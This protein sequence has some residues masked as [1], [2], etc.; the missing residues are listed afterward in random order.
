MKRVFYGLIIAGTFLIGLFLSV[1]TVNEMEYAIVT[2]FGKPVR[3]IYDAGLQFKLPGFFETVNRIDRQINVFITQPI[4]LLLGD[5][6]PIILTCYVCWRVCDPSL[7][8]QSLVL[9]ETA[10]QKLGDM[11]NSQLGSVLGDYRLSQIINT[12][13][14]EVML[15]EIESKIIGNANPNVKAKY[16]L[17]ILQLGVRRINYPSIVAKAVFDRMQSEREK[18]AKKYRAEGAEESAK[19][20]AQTEREVSEI[21]ARAYKESEQ[22]KGEGDREA[23]R[24]Y[25]DAYSRNP[26]YFRFSK[27]IELY[28]ELLQGK[29]SI[30]IST[31]TDLFLYLTTPEGEKQ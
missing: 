30:V 28:K 15:T 29:T 5:Q 23:I 3:I 8:F 11:I 24:I 13:P 22:I 12:D 20:E 9:V 17:E 14:K 16:G 10:Q 1:F 19:I 25:G 21:L 7:F 31:D 6:N 26:E 18:E 27:S 2:R 4:Q